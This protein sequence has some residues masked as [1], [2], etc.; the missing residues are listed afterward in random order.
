MPV[1]RIA[2]IDVE[3]EGV[4][5]MLIERSKK[6]LA[7]KS[8]K[9]QFSIKTNPDIIEALRKQYPEAD[10]AEYEYTDIG[11]SFH[12]EI[13]NY[14]GIMLHASA[15][16]VDGYAYLFSAPSGMGKST[17]T[18]MWQKLLGEDNA[19]IIND[20]KPVIRK[21]NGEYF[22]FGTPFSGKYDISVN[23]SFP[24]KGIC[25][26]LRSEENKIEKLSTKCAV[27]PFLNQTVRPNSTED[28]IKMLNIVDELLNSV[29]CYSLRCKADVDAAKTAYDAMKGE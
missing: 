11:T 25:F 29:P 23:D 10:E 2:G 28:Y 4:Y 22:V 14:N 13:L 7:D 16:A 19:V 1:Y 8:A 6:Y 5:D 3:Y 27:T 24:L 21:I 20:D 17:H 26:V 12:R 9:P 18:R 15:V